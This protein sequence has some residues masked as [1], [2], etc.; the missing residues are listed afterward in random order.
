MNLL[1]KV[2]GLA[3]RWLNWRTWQEIKAE[4]KDEAELLSLEASRE[5]GIE[6]S[7][8]HPNVANLFLELVSYLQSQ[9]APNFVQVEV[10]PRINVG[11]RN[12]VIT[13]AY[14]DGEMP[15]AQCVRLR[16][17]LSEIKADRAKLLEYAFHK[18]GC[19]HHYGHDCDCGYE[20]LKQAAND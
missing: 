7:V 17:E 18:S 5:K 6:L 19:A 2:D 4:A 14:S 13:V 8:T 9:D 12:V 16:K 20:E 1:S 10:K 3:G 11:K 15:G